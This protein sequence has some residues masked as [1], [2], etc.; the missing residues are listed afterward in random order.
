MNKIEIPQ[1]ALNLVTSSP[2]V[3]WDE[4]RDKFC[5]IL[6]SE[7]PHLTYQECVDKFV[8]LVERNHNIDSKLNFLNE[9]KKEI[10]KIEK[11]ILL[12]K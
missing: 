1:K 11:E 5:R 9:Y 12:W 4:T 3:N 7:Y 6:H 8:K 2:I 10:K